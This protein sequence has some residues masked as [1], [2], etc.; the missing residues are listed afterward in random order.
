MRDS[1][2]NNELVSC[3][4]PVYNRQELINECVQSVLAQT[5][6][7]YEIIIV[8]D[9]STDQT[10]DV[11]TKLAQQHA[12][13]IRVLN[14]SNQGPGAARQLGLDH[15]QG[16]YIQFLDSDDLILPK[17]FELF[18]NAF[19]S[20]DQADIVYATT[21]Y[22][23]IDDPKSYFIWKLTDQP[24]DSLL[25]QFFVRR[26]WGT[27]TPIYKHSILK[28]AGKILP[29]SCEEDL[30]YECRVGLQNPK[31]HFIDQHLTDIRHHSGD[32]FSVD[33]ANRG[34]QLSHQIKAREHIYQTML[35]FGLDP[36]SEEIQIFSKFMFLLARQ[37]GELNLSAESNAAFELAQ[38]A[39]EGLS[40]QDRLAMYIYRIINRVAGQK[41]GSEMFGRIY[42][43]LH[44][45]KN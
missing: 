7:H 26:I 33:N 32:R 19:N 10:S 22:Y 18:I 38:K 17:K 24:L 6:S 4:I 45:I 25:P 21:H 28:Q 43:R 5:Y 12:E 31:L 13:K 30:E 14:Q 41:K 1:G 27:A 35:K 42:N 3:I 2:Q 36:D 8:N 40:R 15:A 29:L 11:A 44:K 34:K 23:P 9:G 20:P 37:S 39:S 16:K